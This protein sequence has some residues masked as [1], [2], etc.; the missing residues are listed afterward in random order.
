MRPTENSSAVVLPDGVPA[1]AD[2]ATPR[3]IERAAEDQHFVPVIVK[4]ND[5]AMR[6][7]DDVLEKAIDEGVEQ[8]DRPFVS[9]ALSSVAAGLILAFTAMAVAVVTLAV[10]DVAS[11]VARRIAVALVYPLGFVVC[12]MSG[13]QLFTEHTATAVYPVLDRRARVTRL[14]RLW[15]IVIL[16]NL[17]GGLAGAGLLTLADDVVGAAAGYVAIGHHLVEFGAGTLLVSAILAGWLMAQGAWLI[18]ATPPATSQIASIYIV[19]FLIGLGGLH[20]SI[21]GSV[22]MFAAWMNSDA[23]SIGEVTR[24]IGIALAGNLVGGSLFVAL[25]NYGHIRKTQPAD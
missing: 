8:L 16:G 9:L 1:A 22:E 14:L 25:L 6:H 3:T 7:P 13:T 20:H 19:T 4:R 23:F 15:S 17:V 21:A 12:V 11:P 5:Q 24:F 18:L 10:T 2:Q